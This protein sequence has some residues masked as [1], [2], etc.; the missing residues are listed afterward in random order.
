MI[1]VK[2]EEKDKVFEILSG[3]GKFMGLSNNRFNII[4]NEEEVLKKLKEAGI[5]PEILD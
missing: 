2:P 3:N 4:E 5:E 1:K